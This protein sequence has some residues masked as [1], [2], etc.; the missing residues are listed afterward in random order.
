[1]SVKSAERAEARR[2]RSAAHGVADARPAI[3][4]L[5]AELLPFAGRPVAFYMPVQT[6]IDPRAAMVRAALRGPALLPV[7]TPGRPLTFREWVPGVR[8]Q[9]DRMGIEIPPET[10]RVFRPAAVVVP[11]LAFD[12]KGY[13]LGYGGGFYDRTLAALRAE[14]GVTAVGFAYAAQVVDALTVDAHDQRVDV[15]VTEEAV[16]RF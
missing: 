6:E 7:T 12:L 15:L 9:R 16:R 8:M 3:E 4:W 14:G 2:R 10:A 13:R 5:D 1:M 11:A